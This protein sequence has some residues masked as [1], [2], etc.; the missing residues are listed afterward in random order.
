MEIIYILF[1]LFVGNLLSFYTYMI[2]GFNGTVRGTDNEAKWM[3]PLMSLGYAS[4][5]YFFVFVS[6]YSMEVC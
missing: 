6:S 2:M 5:F 4:V 1:S 3:I